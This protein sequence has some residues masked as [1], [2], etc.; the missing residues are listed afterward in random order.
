[1]HT[2]RVDD[3]KTPPRGQGLHSG[4]GEHLS[5]HRLHPRTT[6]PQALRY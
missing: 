6:G 3:H 1:L 4:H 5:E 2:A